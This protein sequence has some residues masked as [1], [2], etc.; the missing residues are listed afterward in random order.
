VVSRWER[1]KYETFQSGYPLS[2][3]GFEA[4]LAEYETGHSSFVDK[5]K[6]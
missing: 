3:P 2:G 4:G 6:H 5:A 1:E